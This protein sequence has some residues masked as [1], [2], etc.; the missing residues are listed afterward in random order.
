MLM[1]LETTQRAETFISIGISNICSSASE[2]EIKIPQLIEPSKP[3]RRQPLLRLPFFHDSP[4]LWV[5]HTLNRYIEVTQPI[6]GNITQLFVTTKKPHKAASVQTLNNW[7]KSVLAECG[8]SEF[9]GHN[10]RY[11]FASAAF[12]E[13]VDLNVL[14]N[15]AGWSEKSKT[16]D[17]FYKRP[18]VQPN[19]TLAEQVIRNKRK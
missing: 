5:G 12:A 17:K 15:A 7:L 1:A 13:R 9:T 19:T 10:T 11:A 3:G 2:F 8:L 18:I 6:R 4:E 14:K 16:F